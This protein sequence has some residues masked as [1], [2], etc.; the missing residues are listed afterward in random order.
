MQATGI[1]TEADVAVCASRSNVPLQ[2]GR[3]RQ[4]KRD[5]VSGCLRAGDRGP[6][7]PE[8]LLRLEIEDIDDTHKALEGALM[9]PDTVLRC[10]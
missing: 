7:G 10:S 4:T 2:E 3:R 1:P 8:C 9:L 5:E 6:R